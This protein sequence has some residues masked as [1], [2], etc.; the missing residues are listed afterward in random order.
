MKKVAPSGQAGGALEDLAHHFGLSA[1][2]HFGVDALG[3]AACCL[4]R[5]TR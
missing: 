5:Q 1:H 2:S 4:V 3:I